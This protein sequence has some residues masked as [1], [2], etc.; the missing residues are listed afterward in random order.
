LSDIITV[1]QQRYRKVVHRFCS[2]LQ[3]HRGISFQMR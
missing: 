2:S 3:H 1:N